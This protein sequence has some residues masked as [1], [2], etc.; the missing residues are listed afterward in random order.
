M[1]HEL[2]IRE[3]STSF[4]DEVWNKREYSV[5]PKILANPVLLHIKERDIKSTH[6]QLRDVIDRWHE[7]YHGFHFDTEA[8]IVEG[9]MAVLL[10]KL[11]GTP[12]GAEE[13]EPIAVRHVFILRYEN[14][15][16][17]EAWELNDFP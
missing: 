9:E 10:L 11:R 15:V 13:A 8:L 16:I 4:I 1:N 7:R 6:A 12:M 2:Q 5:I 17:V 14:G 3:K